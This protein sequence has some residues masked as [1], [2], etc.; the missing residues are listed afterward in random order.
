MKKRSKKNSCLITLTLV[1]LLFALA[2][3]AGIVYHSANSPAFGTDR[4]ID[5]FIDENTTFGSFIEKL[6]TDARI[7][8]VNFFRKLSTV[9][10]F[11]TTKMKTGRYVV[12]PSMSYVSAI[13]VF[14]NGY[15]TPVRI[16]FN[17]IRLKEDFA[18]RIGEQLMLN[19]KSLLKNLS[20]VRTCEQVGLDTATI[21][22]LFIPDTYE[23]YW[24]VSEDKFFER[25][26]REYKRFWNKERLEKAKNIPL[27]PV[28]VS[29]LASIVEEET[30][31]V[32]DYPLIAGLY[33]NRLKLNMPLQADPT[34]KFAAGDFSLKRI[35]F[36]HL[37]SDSPYNTYKNKGLPPGPIRIPSVA[38]IEA[39]L[40]YTRHDYIY[41]VA[42]DDFSGS[43]SFS[44]SL[45]EHNRKANKY[46]E[47]LN[48]RGIR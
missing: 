17:N 36:S 30:A 29:I 14:R 8:N 16:T 33:I 37:E 42:K 22:T 46:R 26:L 31:I 38:A 5:I 18:Q 43:T 10:K 7:K 4:D 27:S 19:P 45:N 34:V 9:M 39:V 12:S 6:E 1:V 23:L 21:L 3:T 25:M 15:Q 35:L 2:V 47:A 13:R 28:E 24:N 41:M 44:E 40:D 32:T 48:R 11:D 20:N